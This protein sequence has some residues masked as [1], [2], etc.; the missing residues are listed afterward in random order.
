MR[1]Y[2]TASKV[3]SRM[4]ALFWIGLALVVC[5]GILW[6]G[7]KIAVGA[8]HLMLI[9]GALLIGWGLLHRRFSSR[10]GI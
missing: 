6:L 5:W 2:R 7:L 3:R 4:K 1:F 8:I 10:H 9:L